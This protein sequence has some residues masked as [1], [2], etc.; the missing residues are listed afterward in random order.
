MNLI[1]SSSLRQPCIA[2]IFHIRIYLYIA[3]YHDQDRPSR[4]LT[5]VGE[6]AD[7]D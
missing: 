7:D 6:E 5:I 1:D 2:F 4:A 3:Y